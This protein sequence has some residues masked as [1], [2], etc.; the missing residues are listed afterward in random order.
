MSQSDKLN[1]LADEIGVDAILKSAFAEPFPTEYATRDQVEALSLQIAQ[2]RG[3]LGQLLQDQFDK[4][5]DDIIDFHKDVAS[6][7]DSG[8]S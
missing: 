4:I 8:R 3:S 7:A 1:A 5:R 2:F 6:L